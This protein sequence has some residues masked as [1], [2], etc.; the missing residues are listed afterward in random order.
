M[1]DIKFEILYQSKT[2]IVIIKA[3]ENEKNLFNKFIQQLKKELDINDPNKKVIF[4][5]MTLNTKEMYLIV[6]EDNFDNI[7]KEKTNDGIIKLFLDIN[8]EEELNNTNNQNKNEIKKI[9]EEDFNETIS[10]SNLNK[11]NQINKEFLENKIEIE[12]EIKNKSVDINNTKNINIINNENQKINNNNNFSIKEDKENKENILKNENDNLKINSNNINDNNNK[13]SEEKLIE[14]TQI[15]PDI[16]NIKE[17]CTIC[18]KIIKEKIKYE[19]CLC[20][21]CILCETCEK[22]HEHPAIK[23][24]KDKTFLHSLKD[25]HSFISQKQDFNLLLPKIKNIFN[26]T[27]DVIIQ[28]EIDD[29]IEFEPNKTIE[30]PFKIKNFSEQSI[31][32]DDFVIIVTNYSIVNI[33]YDT[34]EKFEIKPKNFISKKLLCFSTDKVGRE[35]IKMEIYSTR[36]KIRENNFVKEE[37]EIVVSDDEENQELNKKFIFYPKIQL[38]NKLRKKML[39]FIIENHF[40]EKPVTDIYESLMKNKWDLDT[41]LYQLKNN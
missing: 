15:N 32:S 41:T 6:N 8:F 7:I 18:K 39:L 35:K 38:L 3:E 37:I 2:I 25:C 30:I 11:D 27:Y 21:H 10:L 29:H 5:L 26:M 20:A 34:K 13:I 28:L 1:S 23:F 24:K 17:F 31:S 22:S 12:D 36:I 33:S 40:V 19:C 9:E 14:S 4:K 16:N